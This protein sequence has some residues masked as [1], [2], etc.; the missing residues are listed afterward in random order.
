MNDT[1][2]PTLVDQGADRFALLGHLDKEHVAALWTQG[3][4]VFAG[5]ARVELDLAAVEHCDSAGMALLIDWL[6]AA[7][8]NEQELVLLQVPGQILELASLV[9]LEGL[10]DAAG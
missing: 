4:Q 2:A 7:A 1:S 6:R 8:V 3:Q 5:R 10:F 9:E